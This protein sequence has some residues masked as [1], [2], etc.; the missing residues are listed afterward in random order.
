MRFI[1]AP[2]ISTSVGNKYLNTIRN[3]STSEANSVAPQKLEQ[4]LV[5]RGY[6]CRSI[7]ATAKF[8]RGYPSRSKKT[9]T[10]FERGSHGR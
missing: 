6:P 9:R 8:E 1:T 2:E 10:K 5:E 7:K 4:N 3:Y